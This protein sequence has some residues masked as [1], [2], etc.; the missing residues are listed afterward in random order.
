VVE[1]ALQADP[2]R[3]DAQ[4]PAAQARQFGYNNDYLAFFPLPWWSANSHI[5]LLWSNHEY[6]NPELMFRG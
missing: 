2:N 1:R 4:T 5:G 6:T 3:F